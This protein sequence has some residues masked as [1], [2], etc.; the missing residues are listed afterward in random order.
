ME[1][2]PKKTKRTEADLQAKV[3]AYLRSR[4]DLLPARTDTQ[5]IKDKGMQD[6]TVLMDGGQYV[7][8]ELKTG[9]KQTAEQKIWQN[10]VER[11]GGIYLL[12]T[13]LEQLKQ[14]L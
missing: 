12:I 4:D 11:L 9:T 13:S 6:I 14:Q 2:L 1:P 3:L 10:K 5:S 8:I 7:A